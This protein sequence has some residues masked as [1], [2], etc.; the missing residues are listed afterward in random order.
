VDRSMVSTAE[1]DQVASFIPTAFGAG[2]D[3]VDVEEA[4]VSA[5]GHAAAALITEKDCAAKLRRDG[6]AG[7]GVCGR[8]RRSFHVRAR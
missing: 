3:V 1:G 7:P 6:L 5:A 2:H 4:G 8:S